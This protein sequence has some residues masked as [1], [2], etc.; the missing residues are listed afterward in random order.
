MY[1]EL[2]NSPE[3][4]LFHQK[5]R[6]FHENIYQ[7]KLPTIIYFFVVEL[8]VKRPSFVGNNWENMSKSE[9]SI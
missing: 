6:V 9:E 2:R 8:K 7:N 4:P 3:N 1:F 5:V